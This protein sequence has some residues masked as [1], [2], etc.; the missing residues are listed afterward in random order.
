MRRRSGRS[1][2]RA[3]NTWEKLRPLRALIDPCFSE[4]LNRINDPIHI[5]NVRGSCARLARSE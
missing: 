1:V 5:A 2:S 4:N 3:A